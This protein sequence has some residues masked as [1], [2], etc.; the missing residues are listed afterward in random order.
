MPRYFFNVHLQA[1]ADGAEDIEGEE[2]ANDEAAWHEATLMLGDLAKDI[3]GKF[4]PGQNWSL[5][6]TD[7]HRRPLFFIHVSS[8]RR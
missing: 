5:E 7:D 3:D 6:V 8:E 1:L 2:L 4:R